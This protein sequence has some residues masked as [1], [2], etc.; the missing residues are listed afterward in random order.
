MKSSFPFPQKKTT[1][2]STWCLEFSVTFYLFVV[3]KNWNFW[4]LFIKVLTAQNQVEFR[5]NAFEKIQWRSPPPH[6]QVI[7]LRQ[8]TLT[9]TQL[10][11]SSI[12]ITYQEI[13]T[14][15]KFHYLFICS[16][17]SRIKT[18]VLINFYHSTSWIYS[19]VEALFRR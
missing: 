10:N 12:F 9:F 18:K 5:E 16:Y 15:W 8:H 14:R 4:S 13:C 2:W 7:D 3:A 1:H 17:Y 11:L 6:F 19:A